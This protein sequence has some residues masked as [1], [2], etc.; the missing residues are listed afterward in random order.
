[1][2][3]GIAGLQRNA[4]VM[5]DSLI[6]VLEAFREQM[7]GVRA[8]G[9]RL[10]ATLAEGGKV[11]AAGNGGSACDALHLCEEL[12]GRYRRER[13][14]LAALC[15]NADP[16]ALT[17]IGN[18]YGFEQVFARQVEALARPGDLLVL[19]TTSGRSRNLVQAARVARA[20]GVGTI[21]ASGRSAGDLADLADLSILVPAENSARVQEVHT[22]VLHSWLERIE[23][24]LFGREES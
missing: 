15:L 10:A 14:P 20:A 12:T 24:V 21:A 16:A 9:D 6:S 23:E 22:F 7:A 1:M 4:S 18:D 2:P 13:R 5:P 11:L 17:C 19:F 3:P 8:A